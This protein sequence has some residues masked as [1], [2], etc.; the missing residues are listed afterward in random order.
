MLKD[1]C[2]VVGVTGGIAA[3]KATSLVSALKKDHA[4]VHVIMTR[5]AAEFISPLVFETLTGNKCMTDTFDRDFKFDVA[6]ISIA[7]A[8]DY[9]VVAPATAN[10]IAKASYGIADD[11]LTTTFLAA[12]CPKLVVPA[13]NTNMYLNPITQDNLI[14]LLKV[15]IRVLKPSSGKLACGDEGVGK[16]PEPD[17][18]HE[19]ILFDLA[20]DKDLK[21]RKV[22][23]TAGATQE[24]I[25]PVRYITNHS[26]GRMGYAIAKAAAYRGAQVTLVTGR[27]GLPPIPYIDTV[28]ITS[29][30]E[31]EREVLG[32]AP[33]ADYIFKAAAVA[34]YT[35]VQAADEK[36]KKQ[37]GDMSIELK[38]TAD[39]LA[40]I[41]EIR[42]PD[43]IICGFSME[44]ENL[45]ENSRSKLERKG[46]DM[47]CANNL[48]EDGAGFG[49]DTNSV[50]IITRSDE[51]ELGK[52]SKFD[53]AMAVI[54]KGI[55]LSNEAPIS[56]A[57]DVTL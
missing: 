50:T 32:Y 48:K 40:E 51:T 42:R 14:R 33:N 10:F 38:R 30:A 3:Y 18:I 15:G 4:D 28:E 54:D 36:I 45:L 56:G 46:L 12:A 19:E 5:N 41:K 6:H 39:I 21:G 22:L 23:V 1:K 26:T 43:Q 8:A 35:P 17:V 16:L 31:M 7:K 47:V 2:V 13:M 53:T 57:R 11:M 44:T 9:F 37:D 29:A 49:G 24:A 52:L 25:D 27:S 55:S 34:D 20:F